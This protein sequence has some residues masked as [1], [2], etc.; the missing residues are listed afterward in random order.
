MPADDVYAKQG[1]LL[2]PFIYL[3]M[4]A[5]SFWLSHAQAMVA[6]LGISSPPNPL[7]TLNKLG[8]SSL[9]MPDDGKLKC[10]CVS[11]NPRWPSNPL[12]YSNWN[13]DLNSCSLLLWRIPFSFPCSPIQTSYSI[14]FPDIVIEPESGAETSQLH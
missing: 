7:E 6:S 12:D 4:T 2:Y 8:T 13:L 5:N 9:P 14:S 10:R 11:P 1:S 3:R